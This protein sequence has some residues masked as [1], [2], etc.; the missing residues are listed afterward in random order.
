MV[1]LQLRARTLR[2]PSYYFY[3]FV[4]AASYITSHLQCGADELDREL[5][6]KHE[7]SAGISELNTLPGGRPSVCVCVSAEREGDYQTCCPLQHD[8]GA[9]MFVHLQFKRSITARTKAS[10][11]QHILHIP[12][13]YALVC[14]HKQFQLFSTSMKLAESLAVSQRCG[15][16]V[17]NR[18]ATTCLK[19]VNT[20]ILYEDWGL[21]SLELA[22]LIPQLHSHCY[23][24]NMSL[25]S[26]SGNSE[27]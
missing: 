23:P 27:P 3:C 18:A 16:W 22:Q 1:S 6:Q 10:F 24:P 5:Q 26:S 15:A 12:L 11:H 8:S 13:L 2:E 17:V 21:G 19:L 14:F 25:Y 4:V 9:F 20:T 7:T